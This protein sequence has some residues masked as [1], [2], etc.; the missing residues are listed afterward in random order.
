MT[1][2]VQRWV[3]ADESL[4]LATEYE[5]LNLLDARL[6]ARK[7]SKFGAIGRLTGDDWDHEEEY[8]DRILT[9][10]GPCRPAT[11]TH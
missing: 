2:R 9:R 10:K 3:R 7:L 5:G 4:I 8:E 1:F 11:G 6:L